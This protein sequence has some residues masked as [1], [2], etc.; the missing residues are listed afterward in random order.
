MQRGQRV[1][2]A[3]DL[4]IARQY[5]AGTCHT[6]LIASI[7]TIDSRLLPLLAMP[8]S[9]SRKVT[10][11]IAVNCSELTAPKASS[12]RTCIANGCDGAARPKL[13]IVSPTSAVLTTRTR[14]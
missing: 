4:G 14:R 3:E 1:D 8:S 5:C 13:A 11:F 7:C 6:Q 2:A 12:C 10:V 9:R